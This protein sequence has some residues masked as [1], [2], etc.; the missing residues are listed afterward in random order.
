MRQSLLQRQLF[1]GIK[2]WQLLAIALFNIF[3]AFQYWFAIWYTSTQNTWVATSFSYFVLKPLLTLPL[4]WLY[5]IKWKNKPIVFKI[6]MH[7]LTAP[8]WIFCW[9]NLYRVFQHW[10]NEG[11]LQGA[12][13]WWDIYIPFLVYCILF[14]I[15]HVYDYYLQTQQQKEKE[16]LL[17]QAAYNSEVNALK[18][19]IQ[20]HFL[21][22]TLNSISASVPVAMEHTR[23]LIAMLADT[24]RYSLKAS[25][26]EWISLRE[27]LDFTKVTLELEQERLK[28]RL[29]LV[30]EID[31]SL[32][33]TK[34]PPMLLQPITENAIKHGIAPHIDGGKVTIG[35]KRNATKIHIS[36]SNTGAGYEGELTDA[37][38]TKG[39]GLRNTNL[40]LKKL[41]GEKISVE[42]NH[43]TGLLFSF[44]IPIADE[45]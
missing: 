18:A 37:I 38:F 35:I 36:I 9:F 7:L 22:N 33:Q 6:F 29:E 24:F 32:L 12:G 31:D 34:V 27:E 20:P 42:R 40:R 19:Q 21:F 13:I 26:Q 28:K 25:G 4:W 23:E 30:Y 14:A 39:I 16:K 45:Q 10:R 15:F 8:V 2:I 41:Y 5:F 17:M 3:F 11:V 1:W 44:N 43:P